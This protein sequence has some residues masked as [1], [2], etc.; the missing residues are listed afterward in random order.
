MLDAIDREDP[1]V[2]ILVDIRPSAALI[3]ESTRRGAIHDRHASGLRCSLSDCLEHKGLA[4]VHMVAALA[5][6][7]TDQR[8]KRRRNTGR[9][10]KKSLMGEMRPVQKKSWPRSKSNHPNDGSLLYQSS[11]KKELQFEE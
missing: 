4:S 3:E 7:A 1:S 6:E 5:L 8:P 10:S 2:C 9:T 11:R